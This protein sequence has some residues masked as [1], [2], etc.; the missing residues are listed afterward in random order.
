MERWVRVN[1]NKPNF[2]EE[3]ANIYSLTYEDNYDLCMSL[4][5][6]QEFYESPKFKGLYFT[7]E[8]YIDYWSR[9]FGN[10]AFTYPVSWSGFNIP[11]RII[12]NWIALFGQ[13][14]RQ[15]E[16]ELIT[17]LL[18]NVSLSSFEQSYFIFVAKDNK[19]LDFTIQHEIAHGMY[20]ID[21]EY[22][23]DVNNLLSKVAIST[24]DNSGKHLLKMGYEYGFID[25]EL[26]AY[27]STEST[28]KKSL[29]MKI[30]F[31]KN[32]DKHMAR[33][34]KKSPVQ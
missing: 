23:K 1:I 5:R 30:P 7:L 14:M 13:G 6:L 28:H 3:C 34:L 20:S 17:I 11:G 32:Y 29:S 21:K 27:W 12:K 8:E 22:R 15:R 24:R 9:D 31:K 2:K 18:E 25:D 4:V 26:Q 33:L 16:L 19:H 10:G